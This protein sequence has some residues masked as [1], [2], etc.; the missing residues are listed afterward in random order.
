MS[1]FTHDALRWRYATKQFDP[2]KTLDP[3]D[4][5]YM[6][7]AGTLAATSYGLQPFRVVVVTDPALRAALRPVAYNQSQ[8]TDSGALCVL[9]ARTDV[10]TALIDDYISRIATTRSLP[11]EAL[12]GF[13]DMMVGHLTNLDS[14]TRLAWAKRQA[15][16]ALGSMMVAAA[17]RHVDTCPMEGFDSTAFNT[18]LGLSD[19][20][21]DAV[22]LLAV[23][24]RHA[25][26]TTQ[27][28]TKVRLPLES[29]VI[30]R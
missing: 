30:R 7:E 23:G 28:Y 27:H 18:I 10:D 3:A 5:D 20:N 4:L 1:T 13:R 22:A 26:D 25:D 12:A 19:H 29:L 8:I 9:A 15:Y 21:L 11:V 2:T 17:E 6:L 14:E 16:I 24:H